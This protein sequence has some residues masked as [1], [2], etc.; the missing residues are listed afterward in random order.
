MPRSSGT[1]TLPAGNPVVTG[2]TISSATHN[3]TMSDITAALTQSVSKDGQTTMTG[4]IPMGG[5]RLTNVGPATAG[6]EYLTATQYQ[7]QYGIY[8]S[9]VGG[10]ADAITLTP[11]PA[12]TAYSPGQRF[13]FISTAVNTVAVTVN[14][15]GLGIKSITKFGT[16]PLVAGD[17]QTSSY[18]VYIEYDGTQFRFINATLLNSTN[19]FTGVNS[20]T[21][22][23]NSIRTYQPFVTFNDLPTNAGGRLFF[24]RVVGGVAV[25]NFFID[26]NADNFRMVSNASAASIIFDM[27][28]VPARMTN[29]VV[30][31]ARMQRT[32]GQGSPL[33]LG[34][35]VT[36]DIIL[37]TARSQRANTVGVNVDVLNVNQSAGTAVINAA[38]GG[39]AIISQSSTIDFGVM[40]TTAVPMTASGMFVVATGGT[41]TLSSNVA[42][43]GTG[44]GTTTLYGLHAI[45]LVGS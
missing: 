10:T 13:S 12:I 27:S 39:T 29:G 44:I 25:S 23:G 3:S 1:Y 2:T 28:V 35:V 11:V 24:E 38:A 7:A 37:V 22:V 20:F 14:I 15:S 5:N 36:G 16:I 40:G 19:T 17:I 18:M 34:T 45:V 26:A 30:P 43:N 41:L 4:N 33:N 31:L 8:V 32:S 21:S 6:N 42:T 9:I